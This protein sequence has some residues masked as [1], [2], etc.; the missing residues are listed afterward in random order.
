MFSPIGCRDTDP[1]FPGR[2][3]GAWG[4]VEWGYG[5]GVRWALGGGTRRAWG[6]GEPWAGGA[7]LGEL[8]AGGAGGAGGGWGVQRGAG[9]ARWALGARGPGELGEG[10]WPGCLE[11]AGLWGL[12]LGVREGVGR[13]AGRWGGW[14][15]ASEGAGSGGA[16]LWMT[17][18]RPKSGT[19]NGHLPHGEAFGYTVPAL[20]FPLKLR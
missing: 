20:P 8:W 6:G 12:G 5:L 1:W 9:V 11:D 18:P 14:A 16:K 17:C 19:Q 7:E 3:G 2:G 15:L 10:C 4:G 13:D